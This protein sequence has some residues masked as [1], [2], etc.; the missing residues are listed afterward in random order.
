MGR[1]FKVTSI[2]AQSY[3]LLFVLCTRNLAIYVLIM[4]IVVLNLV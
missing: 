3:L 4:D 2:D 1:R